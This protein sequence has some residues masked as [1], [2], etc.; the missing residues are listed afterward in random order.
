MAL[1][2]CR[3]RFEKGCDGLSFNVD[4]HFRKTELSRPSNI[5]LRIPRTPHF[6]IPG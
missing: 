6:R 3:I 2:F 4:R 1:P 5:L